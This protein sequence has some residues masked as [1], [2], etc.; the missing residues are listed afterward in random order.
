M[1]GLTAMTI[2]SICGDSR[3][4]RWAISSDCWSISF[5]FCTGVFPA[6][7]AM[8][9]MACRLS[10]LYWPMIATPMSSLLSK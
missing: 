7:S 8:S 10:S 4:F 3:H 2:S 5:S 1:C 6:S 9:W